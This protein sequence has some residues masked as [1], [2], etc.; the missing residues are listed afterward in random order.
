MAVRMFLGF[1]PFQGRAAMALKPV[2]TWR[3]YTT[4]VTPYSSDP[5]E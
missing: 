3:A 5:G 4:K 2:A 1:S